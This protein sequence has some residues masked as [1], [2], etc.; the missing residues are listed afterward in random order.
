V[1]L[2]AHAQNS[3][4]LIVSQGQIEATSSPSN[5]PH[6]MVSRAVLGSVGAIGSSTSAYAR[7]NFDYTSQP[8]TAQVSLSGYSDPT[9]STSVQSCTFTGSTMTAD[10]DG[11]LQLPYASGDCNFR[12]DVYYTLYV[13]I[14]ATNITSTGSYLYGSP[15][16]NGFRIQNW[17]QYSSFPPCDNIGFKAYVALQAGSWS[18]VPTSTDSGILLSGAQDYCNDAFASSTGLGS[19]IANGLCV[20]LGFLF[21]PS[22]ASLAQYADY[23]DLMAQ[24]IPF[25][26][27]YD[28][29]DIIDGQSASTTENFSALSL[30]LRGTGVGSTTPW[31]N[32]LPS[33]FAYLSSTTIMTYVSPTLYDLLFFLM[34]SAIWI[35]VMFHIYR[36]IVPKHAATV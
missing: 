24:V 33:S 6:F 27:Y 2:S 36:R 23:P 19:T 11:V 28:V 5:G 20:A 10:Y 16:S 13:G 3:P 9:Y 29:Q 17:C 8:G 15:T 18:L 1:P 14:F 12:P 25:S 7:F 26:Y 32:V 31:A 35:A 4:L 21:I 22:Q 34:R 30:D